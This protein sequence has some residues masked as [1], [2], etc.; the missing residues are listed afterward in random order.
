MKEK[1][2]F[3][4]HL[5]EVREPKFA[6]RLFVIEGT[7]GSGRSTQIGLLS[8]WLE[9]NGYAV[10]HMGL[11][12]SNL[13]SEELEEAKQGNVLTHTTMSL[14]YATD[15]FDQLVHEIVPALRAGLIVIAD[16]YIY[17]LMARD[18]VRGADR[19]WTRNL[20]SPA[21]VPD[22]VFYLQVSAPRLVE[23]NFQKNS[24]LDYW[25]SGMDLGLSRDMFS[26][27]IKFQ[28]LLQSEFEK[29]QKEFGFE[30]LNGNLRVET[31]QRELRK[32][33]GGLL[34]IG[35]AQQKD[36]PPTIAV[37]AADAEEADI[38]PA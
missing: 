21:L 8:Q 7:D 28:R 11:R 17:T 29:M 4:R 20:Y 15:F 14:F 30:V 36:P 3:G 37:P 16:R 35:V 38:P 6:G 33:I 13:V 23:R 2:F 24:T 18:L 12:R 9:A 25:E 31:I 10:R 34:G 22:A 27:F 32:K 19:A 1:I 5:P 26:S